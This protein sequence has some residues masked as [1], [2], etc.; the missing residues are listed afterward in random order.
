MGVEPVV[1]IAFGDGKG[2]FTAPGPAL[3]LSTNFLA[4][5]YYN[6]DGYAD[7]ASLDGS[8]FEILIGKGNEPSHARS[9]MLSAPTP[10]LF[11]SAI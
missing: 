8:A 3:P 7:L 9:H 2:H 1:Q 5:G 4:A 10:S 6:G 11:F